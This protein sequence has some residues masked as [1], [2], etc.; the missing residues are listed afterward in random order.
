MISPSMRKVIT[1]WL[2]LLLPCAC[3]RVPTPPAAPANLDIAPHT[4]DEAAIVPYPPP[5]AMVETIPD[6]PSPNALWLDGH[7]EWTGRD[8]SWRRGQWDILPAPGAYYAPATTVRRPNG[9]L[10]YYVGRWH[11]ADGTPSPLKKK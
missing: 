8:F 9:Q 3:A 1:R 6:R 11:L 4:G 2:V 10:F 5:P 7:W